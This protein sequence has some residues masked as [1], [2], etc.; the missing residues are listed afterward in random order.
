MSVLSDISTAYQAICTTTAP[1][2]M[3]EKAVRMLLYHPTSIK[4]IGK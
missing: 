3:Q 4:S 1:A 2:V